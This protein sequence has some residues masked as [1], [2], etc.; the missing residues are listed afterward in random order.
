MH[1]IDGCILFILKGEN[2][3]RVRIFKGG[4]FMKRLKKLLNIPV[5]EI[6]SGKLIGTLKDVIYIPPYQ[7]ISAIVVEENSL[8]KNTKVISKDYIRKLGEDVAMILKKD[9]SHTGYELYKNQSILGAKVIGDGGE[10]IGIIE[11]II[12]DD[13]GLNVL[14]FEATAGIVQDL[15]EGRIFIPYSNNLLF[16]GNTLMVSNID[17]IKNIGGL[18]NLFK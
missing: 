13:S 2:K 1:P 6:T 5:V 16:N 14:G 10:E 11:D 9:E 18:K 8:F 17:D 15:L 12:L 3:F 7:S 4:V